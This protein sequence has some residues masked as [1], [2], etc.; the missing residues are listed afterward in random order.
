[1][2]RWDSVVHNLKSGGGGEA[3]A[4]EKVEKCCG[5]SESW[6]PHWDNRRLGPWGRCCAVDAS[7]V[8]TSLWGDGRRCA[9]SETL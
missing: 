8:K 6:R 3:V 2:G 9:Q 5:Q 4:N 1:M 7:V